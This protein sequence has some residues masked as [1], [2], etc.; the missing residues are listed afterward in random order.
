[1]KNYP[2]DLILS[3]RRGEIQ[4]SQFSKKFSYWQKTVGFNFDTK[5][6]TENNL[7]FVTY[8]NWKG[9]VCG[10][11]IFFLGERFESLFQ[12]RR[13]ID[14]GICALEKAR[15]VQVWI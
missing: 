10:K 15:N 8:R 14:F 5:K 3:Y 4:K 7:T 1:M 11:D 2:L 9:I 13:I 12:F 6:I